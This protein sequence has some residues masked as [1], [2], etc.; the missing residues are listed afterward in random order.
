MP[1]LLQLPTQ[2]DYIGKIAVAENNHLSTIKLKT[3]NNDNIFFAFSNNIMSHSAGNLPS[4]LF[5]HNLL[6][7]LVA[8][9][10]NALHKFV[11]KSVLLRSSSSQNLKVLPRVDLSVDNA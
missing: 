11:R 5:S 6:A 7:L 1:K 10:A 3:I 2:N 4:I 8:T 9:S